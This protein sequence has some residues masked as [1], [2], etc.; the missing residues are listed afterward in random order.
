[1]VKGA[2]EVERAVDAVRVEA[3]E[4][5]LAGLVGELL[6]QPLARDAA[7]GGVVGAER[8]RER[9]GGRSGVNPGKGGEWSVSRA[10]TR[11]FSVPKIAGAMYVFRNGSRWWR[12]RCP[13]R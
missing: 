6:Q 8:D 7:V 13:I 2:V 10:A 4:A 3:V 9:G 12:F 1:M 11:S 5:A